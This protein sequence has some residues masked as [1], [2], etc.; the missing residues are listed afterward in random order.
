MFIA[1]GRHSEASPL[2]RQLMSP[3]PCELFHSVAMSPSSPSP[4]RGPMGEGPAPAL[5]C[6]LPTGAASPRALW[7]AILRRRPVN[8]DAWTPTAHCGYATRPDPACSLQSAACVPASVSC[9]AREARSADSLQRPGLG[10]RGE[11]K[12]LGYFMIPLQWFLEPA[13]HYLSMYIYLHTCTCIII[14][15]V[16]LL[17]Y[18]IFNKLTLLNIKNNLTINN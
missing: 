1:C 5:G 6:D 3:W 13:L 9:P 2:Q 15:V 14:V 16:V 18:F 11:E 7:V 12:H 4:Q 8:R 17:S 10:I